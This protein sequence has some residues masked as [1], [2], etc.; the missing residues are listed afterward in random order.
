[1]NPFIITGNPVTKK[2]SQ[3]MAVNRKTGKQFPVQSKS[4]RAY[5]KSAKQ[6]IEAKKGIYWGDRPCNLKVVYYMETHRKVDLTNL[7]GAT[8]DILVK[9]GVIADDNS[10]IIRSHDGSRVF[11]DKEFPRAEITLTEAKE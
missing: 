9:S 2:N 3:Q 10:S 11:Y 6:Q 1:M 4:Y 5:E 7:L 8:C